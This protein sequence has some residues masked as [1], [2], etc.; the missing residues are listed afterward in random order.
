[1]QAI[2]RQFAKI[3]NGSTQFVIPVFQRDYSWTED[4]CAQLWADVLRV[5][6]SASDRGHFMGSLV[7]IPSG[8]SAAGFTRWLL[9][10][11]QQRMTTVMLL[12]LALRKH[13][14]Q[15][16]WQGEGDD[17]P[18]PKR[19]D[20]YFLK[21][22][23]E[24][25]RRQAKLVL[26]RKDDETLRA[27]LEDDDL[28]ANPSARL[29]ENYA[30]FR[31]R[32]AEVDPAVVYKGIGRLVVIDVTLDRVNDDPQMIFESLNSTGLDRVWISS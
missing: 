7:Y 16:G 27:L 11:G 18:T 3:I 8:D 5:G 19:I 17:A 32:M 4:Q 14:Q 22:V 2:N 30:F 25:G 15:S 6:Q 1:M 12:L 31:D 20:A 13:L 9:I 24:E 29:Q 10:D 21:N 26:R 28:P 23:Q